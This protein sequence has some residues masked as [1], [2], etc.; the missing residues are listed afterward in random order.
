MPIILLGAEFWKKAIN[1]DYLLECGMFQPWHDT[2]KQIGIGWAR[3]CRYLILDM[4][5]RLRLT[6]SHLDMLVFKDSAEA[7]RVMNG[8]N[9]NLRPEL[10]GV[11][12]PGWGKPSCSCRMLSSTWWRMLGRLRKVE[13]QSRPKWLPWPRDLLFQL[14][15]GNIEST[16][17]YGVFGLWHQES[18]GCRFCKIQKTHDMI[19]KFRY[20]LWFVSGLVLQLWFW[21]GFSSYFDMGQLV[22]DAGQKCDFCFF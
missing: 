11:C 20:D 9:R 13:R 8:R 5:L 16:D 4:W 15:Q 22:I 19:Q 17:G 2:F 3:W 12:P 14:Q 10:L 21:Y 1:F 7:R 6:Q 18:L